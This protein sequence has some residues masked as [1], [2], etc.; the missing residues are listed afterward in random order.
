LRSETAF[1]PKHPYYDPKSSREAPKWDLVTVG[2]VRK[3]PE[4]VTLSELRS[5]ARPG[6]VLEKMSLLR[7]GRLSVSAVRPKEWTFIL[8]LAG[9]SEREMIEKR[10]TGEKNGGEG[11]KGV[12][13][14]DGGTHE[15]PA[16]EAG[17]ERVDGKMKSAD[18][19]ISEAG[20][21]RLDEKIK[22]ED[23]ENSARPS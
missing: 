1:D 19:E 20:A 5:F 14:F 2:F 13:C 21:E 16:D 23:A 15:G 11:S 10:E 12:N 3:F 17:A 4:M 9:G 22:S 8:D 6:G 7:Q 18:A